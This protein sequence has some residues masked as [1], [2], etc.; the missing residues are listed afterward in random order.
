MRALISTYKQIRWE[1]TLA[2]SSGTSHLFC[3]K[4]DLSAKSEQ[5]QRYIARWM[6]FRERLNAVC[7]SWASFVGDLDA[8]Y[9][10]VRCHL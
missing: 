6:P 3:G 9:E 5:S 8:G 10:G 7:G 2:T 1:I 4:V